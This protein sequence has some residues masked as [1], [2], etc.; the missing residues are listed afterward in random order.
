LTGASTLFCKKLSIP[1]RRADF[2]WK[3]TRLHAIA[4]LP[5]RLRIRRVL[6]RPAARRWQGIAR[7]GGIVLS[8][9]LDQ[10]KS[11]ESPGNMLLIRIFRPHTRPFS[12]NRAFN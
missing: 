6:L 9:A 12:V 1:I 4:F 10:A 3:I 5:L 7:M 11:V 2:C 8:Y